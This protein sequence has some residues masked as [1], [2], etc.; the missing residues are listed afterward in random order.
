VD[1][2]GSRKAAH[3]PHTGLN[4]QI[5][6]RDVGSAQRDAAAVVAC[7]PKRIVVRLQNAHNYVLA[8]LALN[9]DVFR[10]Q[11]H[12]KAVVCA[13]SNQHAPQGA[14]VVRSLFGGDEV[15]CRLNGRVGFPRNGRCGVVDDQL[16]GR[17]FQCGRR[18]YRQGQQQAQQQR[19]PF[20]FCFHSRISFLLCI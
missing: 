18:Q 8:R 20:A 14:V 13:G 7:A 17:R 19:K 2:H 5:F 12:V 11:R 1:A 16:A 9:R 15:D 10:T 3:L 6:Q 4:R